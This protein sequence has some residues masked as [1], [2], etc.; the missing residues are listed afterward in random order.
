[1]LTI[2]ASVWVSAASPDEANNASSK[3]FLNSVIASKSQ[4][5]VPWL[6]RP[7]VSGAISRLGRNPTAGLKFGQG[8]LDFPLIRRVELDNALAETA[9]NLAASSFL[10]GADAVYAAV[11]LA[12]NCPLVSPD[13][14]HLTRLPSVL[15][16][17]TPAQALAAFA[18]LPAK[19][20]AARG[21]PSEVRPTEPNKEPP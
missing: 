5:I 13:N 8:L 21:T 9:A 7:E 2:D 1:M 18:E 17:L 16:V 4:V 15:T 12:H 11:A 3:S 20:E 10:R 6:L 14:E 19:L